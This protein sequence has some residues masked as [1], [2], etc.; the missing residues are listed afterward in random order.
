MLPLLIFALHTLL[1]AGCTWMVMR[2]PS[3]ALAKVFFMPVMAVDLPMLPV[4]MLCEPLMDRLAEWLT[5]IVGGRGEA[6][7]WAW[8]AWLGTLGPL[9]WVWLSWWIGRRIDGRRLRGVA[10]SAV[11]GTMPMPVVMPAAPPTS[12]GGPGGL[13]VGP[14]ASRSQIAP[15]TTPGGPG[16][17]HKAA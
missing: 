5:P 13:G 7:A 8:A 1:L 2:S 14:G 17:V 6:E 12:P 11:N 4:L 3:N 9:P 16:A 10:A 15:P